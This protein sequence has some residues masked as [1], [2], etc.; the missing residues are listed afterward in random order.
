MKEEDAVVHNDPGTVEGVFY[1]KRRPGIDIDLVR[2][3]K[4][5]TGLAGFATEHETRMSV[6]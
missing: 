4:R 1:L 5:R 2:V 6:A 3:P